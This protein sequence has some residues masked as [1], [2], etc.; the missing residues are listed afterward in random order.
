MKKKRFYEKKGYL[1]LNVVAIIVTIISGAL[2]FSGIMSKTTTSIISGSIFL[3]LAPLAVCMLWHMF[4]DKRLQEQNEEVIHAPFLLRG[5]ILDRQ[6]SDQITRNQNEDDWAYVKRIFPIICEK[7]PTGAVSILFG[8]SVT[9]L[10]ETNRYLAENFLSSRK[11][12]YDIE[13]FLKGF[14]NSDPAY[15]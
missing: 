11:K 8:K 14:G 13:K 9:E 7:N 1:I 2:N 15:H 5:D 12:K 6:V 10:D 4:K 3:V